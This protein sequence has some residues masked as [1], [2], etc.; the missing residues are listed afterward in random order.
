MI[1]NIV[2]GIVG[3]IG[4]AIVL[5]FLLGIPSEINDLGKNVS[6]IQGQVDTLIALQGQ[7]K[8]LETRVET[9]EDEVSLLTG[10]SKKHGSGWVSFDKPMDI[11]TGDKLELFI[12]GTAEKVV[13]RLLPEG[14]SQD[15]P[16][17][18]LPEIFLV[19]DNRTLTVVMKENHSNVV[20]ISVHGGSNPWGKFSLGEN[21]GPATLEKVSF[22]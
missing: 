11:K 20:H 2:S 14:K 16:I 4:G 8:K 9:V 1:Q 17:G 6:K 10:K 21:N 13:V 7:L 5:Y 19:P 3:A 12:G 18:I 15:F 22:K